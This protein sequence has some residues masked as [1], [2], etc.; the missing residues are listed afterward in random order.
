MRAAHLYRFTSIIHKSFWVLWLPSFL[1]SLSLTRR[2]LM[3]NVIRIRN[4]IKWRIRCKTLFW[5]FVT[6]TIIQERI[7]DLFLSFLVH[8]SQLSFSFNYFLLMWC[9]FMCALIK[10]HRGDVIC[11]FLYRLIFHTGGEREQ[12]RNKWN[13]M[14]PNSMRLFN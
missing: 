2:S 5:K 8:S 7:I 12:S 1:F 3:Q 11:F 13:T 4:F 10:T 14:G 6:H 9:D